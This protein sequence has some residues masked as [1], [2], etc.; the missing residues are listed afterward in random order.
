MIESDLSIS[1]DYRSMQLIFR[2]WIYLKPIA[3]VV[4]HDASRPFDTKNLYSLYRK[5]VVCTNLN[6][7]NLRKVQASVRISFEKYDYGV[8]CIQGNE[9]WNGL[10]PI[11]ADPNPSTFLPRRFF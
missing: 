3:E 8:R 1:E 6:I 5:W 2:I 7:L 4:H 9:S 10:L 11:L